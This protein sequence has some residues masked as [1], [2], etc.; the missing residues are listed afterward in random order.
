MRTT[1]SDEY[2]CNST[3][4]LLQ[5]IDVCV[6]VCLHEGQVLHIRHGFTTDCGDVVFAQISESNNI[7]QAVGNSQLLT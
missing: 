5:R 7:Y 6:Y 2:P 3:Y 1:G 4:P